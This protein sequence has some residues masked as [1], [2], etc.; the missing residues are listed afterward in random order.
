MQLAA[1]GR[2][3]AACVAALAGM[4]ALRVAADLVRDD[5][6]RRAQIVAGVQAGIAKLLKGGVPRAEVIML[7]GIDRKPL[8]ACFWP[9][10]RGH[11]P[12]PAVVCIGD[13]GEPLELLLARLVPAAAGRELALLLVAQSEI[14]DTPGL[15]HAAT[16]TAEMRL[17]DCVDHLASRS[18]VDAKRIAVRGDGLAG[19]LATRF[20]VS[21]SRIV[22][23]VCDGGLWDGARHR[24]GVN[25]LAGA[26]AAAW[27]PD[28]AAHRTRQAR[29][30][31]YP[32]LVV[33]NA[34]GVSSV[35]EA[36]ALHADCAR[37]G[38]RMDLDVPQAAATA[39]ETVE[40]LL[41]SEARTVGWL[42]AKLDASADGSA[43]SDR[44]PRSQAG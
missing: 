13:E 26:E 43:G 25:W 15:A 21:D 22:A 17:G 6:P 3:D 4:T 31:R 20:A 2:R 35:A 14:Q 39:Q 33:A 28:D 7:P 44:L 32:F 9:A 23:A 11:G 1:E 12:A 27:E 42:V 30:M 16:I 8:Q 5:D 34:R 36:V 18:E 10:A 37:L 29:Q 40:E 19:A 38:V 24:A 41:R